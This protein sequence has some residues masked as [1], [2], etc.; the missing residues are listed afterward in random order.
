[1]LKKM[2]VVSSFV[3]LGSIASFAQESTDS[4]PID[5]KQEVIDVKVDLGIVEGGYTVTECTPKGSDNSGSNS[6]DNRP[7]PSE[8]REAPEPRDPHDPFR[9]EL[10]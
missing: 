2:L 7:E 5:H 1:M 10:Y 9:E 4:C 3:L 6:N 8:P